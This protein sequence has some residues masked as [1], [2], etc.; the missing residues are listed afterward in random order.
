M[1]KSDSKNL[2]ARDLKKLLQCPKSLFQSYI[3]HTVLKE[4]RCRIP[5]CAY[6]L[7]PVDAVEE[8]IESRREKALK[9]L[10]FWNRALDRFDEYVSKERR[11]E[12]NHKKQ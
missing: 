10:S 1:L 5:D 2:L 9:E 11:H 3:Q 12:V 7:Y 6:Y 8:F 4:K